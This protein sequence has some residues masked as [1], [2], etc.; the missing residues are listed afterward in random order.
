M[1]RIVAIGLRLFLGLTFFTAGMSKLMPFPGWIGPQN[2]VAVLDKYGLGPYGV[3][4][5]VRQAAIGLLLATQRFATVG[6]IMLVPMLANILV[7]TIALQW[8]G[9]PAVLGV[10]L[11]MNAWLLWYDRRKLLGLVGP[12]R[13]LGRRRN[14]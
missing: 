3:F 14:K 8:R 4:I 2:L 11:A 9:T 12:D 7:V 10:M 5:A 6:A 1:Q 13:A